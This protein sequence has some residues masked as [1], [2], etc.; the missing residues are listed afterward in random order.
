MS[1]KQ[2]VLKDTPKTKSLV[3]LVI[4][5]GRRPVPDWGDNADIIDRL[6]KKERT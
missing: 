6:R 5:A 4:E 3:E 2:T 1:K